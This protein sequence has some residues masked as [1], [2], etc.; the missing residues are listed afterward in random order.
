ML[1]HLL[2][3]RGSIPN[4]QLTGHC[5]QSA[6]IS[7]QSFRPKK[8]ALSVVEWV[9]KSIKTACPRISLAGVIPKP[10]RFASHLRSSRGRNPCPRT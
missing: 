8:L 1:A 7:T 10:L 2:F 3:C 6:A 4:N 5:E 9:E